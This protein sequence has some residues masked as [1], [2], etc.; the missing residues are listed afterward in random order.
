MHMKSIVYLDIDGVLLANENHI[1]NYA[2]E[3]IQYVVNNYETYWLTTHC[4]GDAMTP[5]EHVGAMFEPETVECMKRI[6][7]TSWIYWKTEAIDFSKPFLW[8]DDDAFPEE[9][10]ALALHG[11]VDNRIIVDLSKDEDQL[12][13]Y[14]TSFPLPVHS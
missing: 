14:I 11:V 6:R 5:I 2:N 1:A 7:A 4:Q 8:F 3:F 12:A 13:K 9:T 10:E